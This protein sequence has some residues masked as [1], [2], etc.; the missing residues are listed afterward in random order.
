MNIS[1]PLFAWMKRRHFKFEKGWFGLVTSSIALVLT[2]MH[3]IYKLFVVG[4][5]EIK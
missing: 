1:Q 4:V 3:L 5:Y 2:F